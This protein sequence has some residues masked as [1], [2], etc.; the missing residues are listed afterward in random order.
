MPDHVFGL[1]TDLVGQHLVMTAVT[2]KDRQESLKYVYV[3]IHQ[4][5]VR[6]SEKLQSL[7]AESDQDQ[8]LGYSL[9]AQTT[10]H[11]QQQAYYLT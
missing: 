11:H 5:L 7:T 9:L 8:D 4:D 1:G 10:H 6:S 2:K 3:L